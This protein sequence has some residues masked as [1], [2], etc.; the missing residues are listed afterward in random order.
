M[1]RLLYIFIICTVSISQTY[2]QQVELGSVD[3]LRDYDEALSQAGEK[4]KEVLILFQEVPGCATC[5]NYGSNVLSDPLMV[6]AIEN[7]FVPLAIFNNKGG[8]DAKILKKYK[9]PTWNNPVVRLIDASGEPILK[10]LAGNYSSTGLIDYMIKSFPANGEVVPDFLIYL[11]A[12]LETK[13]QNLQTQD[14]SMYCF[15]S[16]EGH[17]GKA[18]GVVNTEPG[19]KNGKEIV[20]VTYDTSKISE[21]ELT[22]HAAKA[23]CSEMDAN[24]KFRPDKDPQ[25][26]LKQSQYRY[27]AL[28]PNQRTLINSMLNSGKDPSTILSP[29]QESYLAMIRANKITNPEMLYDQEFTLAWEKMETTIKGNRN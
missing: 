14:Y 19:F 9:E 18:E 21:K 12:H 2:S 22:K 7:Y 24:G 1:N 10:R 26:Y 17:I 29:A 8:E 5:R 4:D 25:Y 6:D 11:Q 27:L 13:D 20:R 23:K 28:S 3:W 15:W 16:G